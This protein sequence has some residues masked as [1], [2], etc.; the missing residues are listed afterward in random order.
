MTPR[1][2]PS[3]NSLLTPLVATA[4]L[5]VSA[6]VL[7]ATAASHFNR[8]TVEDERRIVRDSQDYTDAQVGLIRQDLRQIRQDLSRLHDLQAETLL[9]IK[10]KK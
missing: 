9:L 5:G 4:V 8:L 3:W 7:Q 10:A 6:W 1:R 2:K